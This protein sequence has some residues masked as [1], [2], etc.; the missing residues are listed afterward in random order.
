M[1]TRRLGPFQIELLSIVK[2][3]NGEAY[4]A[5]IQRELK[6]VWGEDRTLGAI[7]TTLERLRERKLV[8]AKWGEK[9][10]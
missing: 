3:Y 1:K 4:G 5:V 6:E 7:Y 2:Q 10:K 9:T 8:T